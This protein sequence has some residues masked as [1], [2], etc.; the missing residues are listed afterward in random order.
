MTLASCAFPTGK[1]AATSGYR[2]TALSVPSNAIWTAAR[3]CVWPE[4]VWST[5]ATVPATTATPQPPTAVSARTAKPHGSVCT[6]RSRRV[7]R[8]R[9]RHDCV[10]RNWAL[11]GVD[12]IRQTPAVCSRGRK[13]QHRSCARASSSADGSARALQARPVPRRRAAGPSFEGA[14]KGANAREPELVGDG[15][16]GGG[17]RSQEL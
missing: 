1:E 3:G 5:L 14:A 6:R 2:G 13:R 4:S 12:P 11:L 15:V 8:V 9:A 16:Q 10:S 17:G 7:D